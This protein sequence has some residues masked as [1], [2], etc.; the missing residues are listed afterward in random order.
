MTEKEKLLMDKKDHD[1][2]CLKG[3]IRHLH[4]L[5]SESRKE[6]ELFDKYINLQNR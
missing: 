4:K 1:I 5:L 6:S 2:G 3:Q